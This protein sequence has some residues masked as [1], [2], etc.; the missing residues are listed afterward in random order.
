MFEFSRLRHTTYSGL[1]KLYNYLFYIYF[2]FNTQLLVIKAIMRNRVII[3]LSEF[4]MARPSIASLGPSARRGA[5]GIPRVARQHKDVLSGDRRARGAKRRG[6]LRHPGGLF[7]RPFLLAEQKKW[8][9]GAGAEPPAIS[10]SK[11]KAAFWRLLFIHCLDPR[12]R[13]D[14]SMN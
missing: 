14:D 8:T 12:L 9:Q 2:Q 1:N 10:F 7:F 6:M 11:S 3:I 5:G 13:V 4:R